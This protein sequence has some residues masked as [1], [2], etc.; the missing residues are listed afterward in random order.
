MANKVQKESVQADARLNAN[1]NILIENELNAIGKL[2]PDLAERA[3]SLLEESMHHKMRCD[4]EIVAVEKQNLALKEL[5][6][7]KYYNWSAFGMVCFFLFS[8]I[9]LIGGVVLAYYDKPTESYI[10]FGIASVSFMPKFI[11][12]MRKK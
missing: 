2:P 9:A 4:D 7:R 5:E 10:A 8:I 3:M 11:K 12:E 1:F 6:I